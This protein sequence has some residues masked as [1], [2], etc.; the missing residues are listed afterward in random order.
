MSCFNHV[1]PYLRP[2]DV[3]FVPLNI[4]GIKGSLIKG[5]GSKSGNG[6]GKPIVI[7]FAR[8]Q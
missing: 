7:E 5:H 6:T 8:N 3:A 2:I 4:C 1:L